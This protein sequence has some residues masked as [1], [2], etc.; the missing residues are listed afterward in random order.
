VSLLRTF[1][2]STQGQQS[3]AGVWAADWAVTGQLTGQV[4]GKRLG[5]DWAADWA[6]LRGGIH[7]LVTLKNGAIALPAADAVVA[8]SALSRP[9][10][11]AT[12]DVLPLSTGGRNISSCLLS[13]SRGRHALPATCIVH[14][15]QCQSK[16]LVDAGLRGETLTAHPPVS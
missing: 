6:A 13:N 8:A 11:A 2:G 14:G 5:S 3:W 4:T 9:R 15:R 1:D 12:P 10:D 7:Q 16:R